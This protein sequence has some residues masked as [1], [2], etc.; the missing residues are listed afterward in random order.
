MNRIVAVTVCVICVMA[1]IVMAV[2]F[3][4]KTTDKLTVIATVDGT[5]IY[6]ETIDFMVSGYQFSQ[7]NLAKQTDGETYGI[8]VPTREEII[9]EQIRNTVTLQ[10]AKRLGLE[11]DYNE[12]YKSAKESYDMAKEIDDENYKIILEYMK[13]RN[14]SEK[15]YLKIIAESYQ[16]S[17]TR[18]NLYKDYIKD[19]KGTEAE[20]QA[21]FDGYVDKLVENAEIIYE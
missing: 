10:E 18:H 20:L 14:L 17:F 6:K 2:C 21:Q 5:E 1:T 7:E 19:K 8:D 3:S 15:E 9:S 12:A 11:A 16:N 4:L 13:K